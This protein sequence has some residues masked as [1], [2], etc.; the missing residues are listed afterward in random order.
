MEAIRFNLIPPATRLAR[1]RRDHARRWIAAIVAAI[2]LDCI[3]VAS[4]WW[5]QR[6]AEG[7]NGQ[8]TNLV[9]EI[10]TLRNDTKRLNSTAAELHAQIERAKALR[11]KRAW[12]RMLSLVANALPKPC[13]L[14]TFATEPESPEGAAPQRKE[15]TPNPASSGEGGKSGEPVAPIVVIEA[16]RRLKL[17]GMAREA[18]QPLVFVSALRE[19]GVFKSVALER[20]LRGNGSDSEV[21]QF[22]LVCEW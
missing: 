13:W 9:S 12:S 20:S 21:F 2:L 6:E 16:P 19:T 18:T 10:S 3:P 17:S 14:I 5:S 1:R 15:P 22:E 4:H 11:S 7:L 8:L